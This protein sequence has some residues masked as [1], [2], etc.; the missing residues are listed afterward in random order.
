MR[1]KIV[2]Q[3]DKERG[4]SEPGRV[5]QRAQGRQITNEGSDQVF[6]SVNKLLVLISDRINAVVK[7]MT[8]QS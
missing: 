8:E 4:C 7:F 3:E 5:L 1:F 6:Q 2:S